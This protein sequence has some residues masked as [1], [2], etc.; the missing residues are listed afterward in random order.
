MEFSRTA[1]GGQATQA[2]PDNARP[3]RPGSPPPSRWQDVFAQYFTLAPLGPS[4]GAEAAASP[5]EAGDWS[6]LGFLWL[7]FCTARG[8]LLPHGDLVTSFGLLLAC[9]HFLLQHVPARH[10]RPGAPATGTAAGAADSLAAVASSHSAAEHLPTIRELEVLLQRMAAEEILPAIHAS[11]TNVMQQ[12]QQ[13]QQAGRMQPTGTAGAGDKPEEGGE[14]PG[15]PIPGLFDAAGMPHPAAAAALRQSYQRQ[16]QASNCIRL[17][18]LGCLALAVPAAVAADAGATSRQ[19]AAVHG[20]AAGAGPM[21]VD[22]SAAPAA[23]MAASASHEAAAL[24]AGGAAA[25]GPSAPEAV[26]EGGEP[27][28]GN[29]ALPA[30]AGTPPRA[31]RPAA[32]ADAFQTPS[33]AKRRLTQ[34]VPPATPISTGAL[35]LGS[36]RVLGLAC[37]QAA[38]L[39][40]SAACQAPISAPGQP[41]SNQLPSLCAWRH[42]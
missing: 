38:P 37:C 5:Q 29:S 4:P 41:L 10:Q 3:A 7:L 34:A 15:L 11:D 28:R 16:Q 20:A 23:D 18:A 8:A 14:V 30:R 32:A 35:P 22:A 24:R 31:P 26:A 12:Q 33:P 42:L 2:I 13:Q 9:T 6:P 39:L 40:C 1:G 27:V 36:A 21:E 17:D 19:D 25:D